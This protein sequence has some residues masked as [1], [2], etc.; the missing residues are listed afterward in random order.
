MVEIR[1]YAEMVPGF[2][3]LGNSDREVLLKLHCLDL[4]TLRLALRWVGCKASQRKNYTFI[5]AQRFSNLSFIASSAFWLQWIRYLRHE[6]VPKRQ[7]DL[8]PER[9]TDVW[10]H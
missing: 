8:T 9:L 7:F 6:I 2:M 4:M 5:I 1:R 3:S 10:A